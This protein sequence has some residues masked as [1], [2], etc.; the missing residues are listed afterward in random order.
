[1][2]TGYDANIFSSNFI[3]SL[4]QKGMTKIKKRLHIQLAGAAHHKH[5]YWPTTG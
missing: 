4:T 5:N 3:G 2:L 1:M